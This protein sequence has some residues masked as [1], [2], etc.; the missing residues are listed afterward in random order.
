MNN[1]TH[2]ILVSLSHKAILYSFRRLGIL[3]MSLLRMLLWSFLSICV[4][5][6][7][8]AAVLASHFH[9]LGKRKA[10]WIFFYFCRFL[11]SMESSRFE[12]PWKLVN[13]YVNFWM[14]YHFKRRVENKQFM[15]K[16]ILYTFSINTLDYL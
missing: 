3:C 8:F 12:T 2:D 5:Q 14:N 4:A 9:C 7:W 15:I 13:D 16:S 1:K 6:K 11:S 10:V